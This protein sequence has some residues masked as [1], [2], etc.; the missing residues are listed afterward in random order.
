MRCARQLARRNE[1]TDDD[2]SLP[3]HTWRTTSLEEVINDQDLQAKKGFGGLPLAKWAISLTMAM[4]QDGEATR[5]LHCMYDWL[6]SAGWGGRE[7]RG[8][9]MRRR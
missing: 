3:Y 4:S 9:S 1:R 2:A 6:L 5:E 7:V 8:D